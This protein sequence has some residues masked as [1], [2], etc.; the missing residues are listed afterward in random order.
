MPGTLV[1]FRRDLRLADNPA[2]CHAAGQGAVIPVYVHAPNEEAEWAPGG[3]GRWWLHHSLAALDAQLQRLGSRLIIRS[4]TDSL[5]ELRALA[6]ETGAG[7]VAWNRLYD[8]LLMQRD[9]VIKEALRG[10]GLEVRSFNAAL[11]REPWT[12]AKKDGGP[13]KAF[14]PFWR[15][16]RAMGDAAD[17]QPVPNALTGITAGITGGI[18]GGNTGGNTSGNTGG[19]TGGNTGGNTGGITGGNTG[20]NTSG[21]T[22]ASPSASPSASHANWP[23]STPIADLALLPTIPWDSAFPEN[24]TPGEQGALDNLQAFLRRGLPGYDTARDLP[25]E[26]G[27]SKLSPHLHWGEIGPRQIVA[28]VNAH[29]REHRV[30]ED[31]VASFLSELGWREFA[32]H[33]LYHQPQMPTAPLD[34]RFNHFPWAT[35]T[36]DR[37][38]AW[39]RGRTGIPIVDAGMRQLYAIGWMHNRVRMV[40]G[41]LLTKNLRIPWQTGEAWFWDT[42]VDAD[43]ASNS[44][45]WQWIQGSG[46]D[47]APFFRIFNPVLQGQRFDPRG[48]YV[49]EWVPELQDMPA[50][51]IH[52]PWEAPEPVLREARV[53]L[54]VTY[55]EPIVDL[56]LSRKDALEAFQAIRNR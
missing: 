17:P 20:G 48:D 16:L 21:N 54:G 1:W 43:L 25:A 36:A 18:T 27:T 50:K 4:G 3:A 23:E 51:H 22:G 42:L 2:L 19:I 15:A 41:S 30:P 38:R 55:P 49:R 5:A 56:K 24:W 13:Y 35:N 11:L 45:G 37:L 14:T 9:A 26:H 6:R 47:A 44:M 28:A 39:Q 46:A 12:V 31:D 34:G 52:A 33:L 53:R 29:V 10:D 32:H 7:H 8:P 40:V